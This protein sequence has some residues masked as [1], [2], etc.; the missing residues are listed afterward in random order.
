MRSSRAVEPVGMAMGRLSCLVLLLVLVGARGAQAQT[1]FG[2]NRDSKEQR[3][4]ESNLERKSIKDPEYFKKSTKMYTDYHKKRGNA[5]CLGC[6]Y[7]PAIKELFPES[8]TI[9]DAGCGN[10]RAT[11]NFLSIGFDAYGVELYSEALKF[12]QDLIKSGRVKQ[13]GLVDLSFENRRFDVV[14]STD[15]LEHVPPGDVDTSICHL[16]RVAKD[17]LWIQ[18]GLNEK[19]E[20]F[21]SGKNDPWVH[22]VIKPR[23][24]WLERFAAYGALEIEGAHAKALSFLRG[25]HRNRAWTRQ[26]HEGMLILKVDPAAQ[27][28]TCG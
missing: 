25:R 24:W 22:E 27:A 8:S 9:L 4:R 5:K 11:R 17:Y 21:G 1:G 3:L 13:E 23:K 28:Q 6:R 14:F 16:V 12:A 2:T 15:V 10:G 20:K 19:P 26:P 7:A 18:V